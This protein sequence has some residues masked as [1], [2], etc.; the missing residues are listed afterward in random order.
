M[1]SQDDAIDEKSL[2]YYRESYSP[3]FIGL[4]SINT[5]TPVLHIPSHG[6]CS[7]SA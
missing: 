3:N 2:G 7:F 1:G 5:I 6:S 4:A